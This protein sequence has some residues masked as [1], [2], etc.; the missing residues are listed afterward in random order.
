M[1]A[2]VRRF[3]PVPFPAGCRHCRNLSYVADIDGPVHPCC[4]F[5]FITE[6]LDFC[7]ACRTSDGHKRKENWSHGR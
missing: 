2:A 3:L 5:W 4:I 7:V 6:G 1:A